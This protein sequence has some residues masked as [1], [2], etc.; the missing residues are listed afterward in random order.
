VLP[1]VRHFHVRHDLKAS[2][3]R[4]FAA[5]RRDI[6]PAMTASGYDLVKTIPD[7]LL[8]FDDA[9]DRVVIAFSDGSVGTVLSAQGRAPR[10]VR[11]AFANLGLS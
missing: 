3:R 1:G 6:I 7:E 4:V 9:R 2:R 5:A 10:S 8:V 11:K